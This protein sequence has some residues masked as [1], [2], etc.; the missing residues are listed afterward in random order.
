MDLK[1]YRRM[2]V[3]RDPRRLF[4]DVTDFAK[5]KFSE[6][7]LPR[8]IVYVVAVLSCAEYSEVAELKANQIAD[9]DNTLARLRLRS[10]SRSS[11]KSLARYTRDRNEQGLLFEVFSKYKNVFVTDSHNNFEAYENFFRTLC[12]SETKEAE[13]FELLAT[14]ESMDRGL[15][16]WYGGKQ[17]G[18]MARMVFEYLSKWKTAADVKFSEFLLFVRE[19]TQG[20]ESTR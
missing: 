3:L 18:Q 20:N 9:G 6:G 14:Q 10:K 13:P 1:F 16:Q 7:G 8:V 15:S 5:I 17:N 11:E 19:L 12:T 2:Q 4:L